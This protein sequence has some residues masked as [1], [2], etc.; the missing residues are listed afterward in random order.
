MKYSLMMT[1]AVLTLGFSSLSAQACNPLLQKSHVP[2]VLPQSMLAQNHPGLRLPDVNHPIVGLWHVVHTD[3]NGNLFLEGFD[4]WHRDGNE[5]E[6]ANL[7]PASGPLCIGQWAQSGK[8]VRLLAH[9][10]FLYDLNNNYQGTLNMT[11]TN[12][13]S[14]KGNNY[15]GT[16]DAKFYDPNG[17]QVNE[18]TGTSAAE[19]LVDQ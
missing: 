2:T 12:Q 1:A 10:T 8:S 18:V 11:Q 3:S 14:G 17:N 16:F 4:A 15:T 9:V 5:L 6:N 19:R 13:V 7:P